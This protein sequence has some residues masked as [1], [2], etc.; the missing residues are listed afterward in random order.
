MLSD[1][2]ADDDGQLM[3]RYRDG[4]VPAFEVLYERHRAALFR[5]LVRQ[6]NDRESAADVFQE[7]WSRVIATR[8][9][10][11][12]RASFAS[13]LYSVAHNCVVDHFRRRTRQRVDRM[14]TD[15]QSLETVASH[16]SWEPD[17]RYAGSQ[18]GNALREALASL[19]PEQ[20]EVFLLHEESAL[21]LADVARITGVGVETAKSRLRYALA[22]LRGA[23]APQ[24]PE[25]AGT[26][27]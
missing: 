27:Q 7:V 6:L 17:Q 26:R 14:D 11:E 25:T 10:Y 15:S 12:A 5:Y 21:G 24:R 20:R 3:L 18:A 4:D 22:K 9:R 2:E 1:M 13:F 19:P 16:H 8:M 23:L